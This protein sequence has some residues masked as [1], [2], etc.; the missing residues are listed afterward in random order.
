VLNWN[1][2]EIVNITLL[3]NHK[4]TKNI[5]SAMFIHKIR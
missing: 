2:D 3:E 4:F 1:V 5:D